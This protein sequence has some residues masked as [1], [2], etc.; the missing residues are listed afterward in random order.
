MTAI[1]FAQIANIPTPDAQTLHC[2]DGTA[3]FTSGSIVASSEMMLGDQTGLFTT[4]CAPSGVMITGDQTGLFTTSCAP[5]GGRMI[6]GD[7]VELFT[8]SC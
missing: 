8:T 7:L 6:S 2:G 5:S 3:L 1:A 4:S